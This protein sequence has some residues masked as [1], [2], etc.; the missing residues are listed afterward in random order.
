MRNGV[1]D[2]E[3]IYNLI[4]AAA[5]TIDGNLTNSRSLSNF[6]C[7]LVIYDVDEEELLLKDTEKVDFA[8]LKKHTIIF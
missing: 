6:L 2:F 4:N 3:L 8:L 5:L 7:S 1:I